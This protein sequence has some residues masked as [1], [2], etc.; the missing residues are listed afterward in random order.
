MVKAVAVSVSTMSRAAE[1]P[2]YMNEVKLGEDKTKRLIVA[3]SN[4]N[5]NEVERLCDDPNIESF[6][7]DKNYRFAAEHFFRVVS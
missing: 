6:I 4:A 2:S 3:A 5:R 7:N 1:M